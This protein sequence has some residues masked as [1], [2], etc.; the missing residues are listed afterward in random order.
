LRRVK[1][2]L[3][4]NFKKKSMKKFIFLT[5]ALFFS[6]CLFAQHST[7][8]LCKNKSLVTTKAQIQETQGTRA[9]I[10]S[11][12]FSVASHWTI[13]HAS[14]TTGDWVI[15]TGVPS[16]SYPI[17]GIAS[18]TA[19][20]GFALFDSDLLCSGNQVGNL[21]TASSISCTGHA[22]VQLQFQEMYDRWYDSTFVYVSNN[23]TTWTKFPVNKTFANDQT[24]ANPTLVSVNISSAAGNKATVWIRFTFYSPTAMGANAGCGYSWMIDDVKLQDVPA[25]DLTAGKSILDFDGMSHYDAVPVVLLG[26]ATYSNIVQNN[27]TAAQTNVIMHVDINSSAITA[28]STAVASM[29]ASA[30]DTLKAVPTIPSTVATYGA[31]LYV[32]QTQTDANPADNVGD[33][34]YFDLT[35]NEYFRTFGLTKILT[36][37]SFGTGA[38]A[39]KGMEYGANYHFNVAQEV[40]TVYAYIYSSTANAQIK[41]K[42]YNVNTSTGARTVVDSSAIITLPAIPY[43]SA[44]FVAF[45][46]VTKYTTAAAS[47]LSATVALECVI[48]NHD[49]IAIGADGAFPG[50]AALAG[51]AYLY[52]SSAWGWHSVAGTVPMVG[53]YVQDVT[54][55]LNEGSL[56]NLSIYPNP[57]NN[58]LNIINGSAIGK[59]KMINAVG[60]IVFESNINTG[61]YTINTSDFEKG[62]YILQI[63]NEKGITVKKVIICR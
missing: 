19:A 9:V 30:I 20:N 39:T 22:N 12:D 38:P 35:T 40:D 13:A 33:S 41:A 60:Q 57:A 56:S 48:A 10:W 5:I 59:V 32:S 2:Q 51:L 14:G 54:T 36:P 18:T 11:D 49:T 1:Q 6:V 23:G 27:G 17:P 55:G 61:R 21:S 15:G 8:D 26:V 25:N 16:G 63:E 52:A 31:K 29:A 47:V 24:S 53:L 34:V 58:Q 45:P 42:L 50:N 37:Y 3:I 7:I 28:Q 44:N 43:T 62:M 4:I 46:L